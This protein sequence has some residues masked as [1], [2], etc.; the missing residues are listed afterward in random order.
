MT[1]GTVLRITQS[2]IALAEVGGKRVVVTVPIG[3]ILTVIPSF[4]ED[5]RMITMF[6]KDR[7]VEMFAI[8]VR[9]R[10]IKVQHMAAAA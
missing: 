10:G 9:T 1:P 4:A 6:W 3:S 2:T 5:D 7:S 8:D